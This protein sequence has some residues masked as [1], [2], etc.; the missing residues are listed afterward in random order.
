M[1]GARAIRGGV[2]FGPPKTKRP[3]RTVALDEETVAAL[4]AHRDA[5]LLERAFLGPAYVD[6]DLVF[7]REDGKPIHPQ[8][9]PASSLAK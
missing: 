6:H 4:E 2:T 1:V 8:A 3:R 5:Q 7:A 9:S